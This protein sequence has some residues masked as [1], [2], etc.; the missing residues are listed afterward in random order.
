MDKYLHTIQAFLLAAVV[1]FVLWYT[2]SVVDLKN[3]NE[4][5][6]TQVAKYHD[7]VAKYH[8]IAAREHLI[9]TG[10][11]KFSEQDE[12]NYLKKEDVLGEPAP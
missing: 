7:Q 11:L 12:S 3:E 1:I 8:A 9:R 2:N 5:L 6:R 10:K 4:S